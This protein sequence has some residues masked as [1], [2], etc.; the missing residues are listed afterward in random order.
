MY[1]DGVVSS[2]I[3][4]GTF[5]TLLVRLDPQSPDEEAIER[6]ASIIRGGR[7]VAFPTETVYGLGADAMNEAAVQKIFE[8]KGRP[9]D[10]PIIVHV[11]GGEML[12][13]VSARVGAKAQLLAGRFWPGPLSMVLKR[14]PKISALVSAGL[15]TVA[16][17][18]PRSNIAL[19]LIR[20]A[21]T[22]V[23][24]PSAN[25]S[26]RPSP[27]VASHVLDDLDGKID[28]I[29]DGGPTSIGLES[30]VLDMT[31]DPPLILRPGWITRE[32]LIEVVGP[33]ESAA[34]EEEFKRSPGTRHPHYT[35]RARVV[36]VEGATPSILKGVLESHLG[37]G[38]TG[39]IGHTAG[40]PG[41]P[42][43]DA[44]TVRNSADDYA[45]S[46]Y[47]ALRELDDR[48]AQVV[49]VEGIE[50]TGEGAA[51]M[52]RLRRAA[53]EILVNTG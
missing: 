8:A 16:V 20:Q 41:S 49:V 33:V 23:A 25:I 45:R 51:V 48:G 17:R 36:L 10:N 29:L 50:D 35:P 13:T 39:F 30:T 22:P 40:L 53:S 32:Q 37:K 27:T 26:G 9:A 2:G 44:V 52:D 14:N 3:A 19:G 4:T 47:N 28:L 24:A 7:L 1:A 5:M 38:K 42:N 18:M 15:D 31:A 11:C 6:A 46:I 12:N 43:L 21:G 34:T